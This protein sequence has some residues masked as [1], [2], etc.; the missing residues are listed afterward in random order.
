MWLLT[1]AVCVSGLIYPSLA[2]RDGARKNSCYNHTIDH[3]STSFL[4]DCDPS[5]CRYFLVI[6]EVFMDNLTDVSI[7]E[8]E[9]IACGEHLYSSEFN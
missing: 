2:Y 1:V 4:L 3:G 7:N 9:S 5:S 8:T 6:K